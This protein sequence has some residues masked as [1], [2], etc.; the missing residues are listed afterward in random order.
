MSILGL[1]YCCTSSR[2]TSNQIIYKW[3][4]YSLPFLLHPFLELMKTFRGD[5]VRATAMSKH[6]KCTTSRRSEE[7]RMGDSPIGQ[8]NIQGDTC[9]VQNNVNQWL[10]TRRISNKNK[11]KERGVNKVERW[12]RQHRCSVVMCGCI[13]VCV[14]WWVFV[15]NGECL[16]AIVSVCAQWWVFVCNGEHL[17]DRECTSVGDG[18][19]SVRGF[20]LQSPP[21]LV[22]HWLD[23]KASDIG[24]KGIV[25]KAIVWIQYGASG[26]V[27]WKSATAS[28]IFSRFSAYSQVLFSIP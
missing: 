19:R 18:M 10:E 26:W 20:P 9:K 2:H 25:P 12:Q 3:F 8:S 5:F 16:C 21:L 1:H 22:E 14:Q 13:S 17:C 11:N 28:A 4:G 24:W 6:S 23:A 27:E 15:C 7:K